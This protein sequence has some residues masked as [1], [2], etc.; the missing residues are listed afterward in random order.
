MRRAEW[1]RHGAKGLSESYAKQKQTPP[2]HPRLVVVGVVVVSSHHLHSFQ[3]EVWLNNT[4]FD[5]RNAHNRC[6]TEVRQHFLRTLRTDRDGAT[7]GAQM[8]PSN[9]HPRRFENYNFHHWHNGNEKDDDHINRLHHHV[10]VVCICCDH[11][12]MRRL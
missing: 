7:S 4:L 8:F 6:A 1:R 11:N 5:V 3:L 2:I 12:K 9:E 10:M